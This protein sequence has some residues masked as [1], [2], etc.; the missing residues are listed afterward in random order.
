MSQ[1]EPAVSV[2]QGLPDVWMKV[3]NAV[4]SPSGDDRTYHDGENFKVD[5]PTAIALQSAGQAVPLEGEELDA[6]LA[7]ESA[8]A[9]APPAE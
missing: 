8:P 7:S 6:A 2:Y 3:T 1:Q 4:I 9:E 5:G